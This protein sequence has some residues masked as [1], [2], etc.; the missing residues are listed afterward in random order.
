VFAAYG[1]IIKCFFS[2][3]PDMKIWKKV[4]N[5]YFPRSNTKKGKE[6]IKKLNELPILSNTELNSVIGW[7]EEINAIGFNHGFNSNYYGF[8]TDVSWKIDIPDDCTEITV[9]E[10]NSL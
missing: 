5:G 7:D 8:I 6:I 1:G 4:E 9:T 2:D 3:Q 10:Y